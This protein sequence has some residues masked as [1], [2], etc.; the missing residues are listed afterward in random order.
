MKKSIAPGEQETFNGNFQT[1]KFDIQAQE[2]CSKQKKFS[3]LTYD[4]LPIDDEN[5][6]LIEP[7]I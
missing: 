4:D 2:E 1:G 6:N 7:E 5:Q 3:V